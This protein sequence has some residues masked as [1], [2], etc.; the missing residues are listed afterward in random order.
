MKKSTFFRKTVSACKTPVALTAIALMVVGGCK[1]D[2]DEAVS[3][4]TPTKT[5]M[6]TDKAWK[7]T[8]CTITPA[9]QGVTNLYSVMAS[10]ELDNTLKFNS[11]ASNSVVQDEGATKCNSMDP[12]QVAGSWQLN[13]AE[14]EV[15]LNLNNQTD[16]YV[17]QSISTTSMRVAVTMVINGTTYTTTNTY[18]NQ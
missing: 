13:S 7:L 4:A 16:T 2:S 3:P 6:L 15:M 18:S 9:V 5:Q 8:A 11:D 14:T 1:K 12:Q 10:C 17:L